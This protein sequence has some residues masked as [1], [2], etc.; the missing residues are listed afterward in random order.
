MWCPAPLP[1][2]EL[3][4]RKLRSDKYKPPANRLLEFYES[5]L[6][7]EADEDTGDE[8][9]GGDAGAAPDASGAA[10]V[11]R[12]MIRLA[13]GKQSAS[14]A[15]AVKAAKKKKR[16]SRVASPLVVVTPSILTPR[17]WEVESEEEEESEKEKDETIEELPVSERPVRRMESPAAK[18]QW[19]L[20]QKISEDALRR[21]LE[22]QRNAAAAQARMPA[23]I[24]PRVF[25]PK[26]RLPAVT[27]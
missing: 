2:G 1:E 4:Q 17:S 16:K 25:W 23:A 11:R 14:A 18:R 27:R 26:A 6:S 13:V 19:E 21:G 8:A 15:A 3:H 22:A 9:E 20:V 7:V 24:K 10:K 12:R 5:D